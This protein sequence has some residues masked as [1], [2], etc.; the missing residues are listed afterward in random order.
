[1][2]ITKK[3]ARWCHKS[4]AKN[5]SARYRISV[6]CRPH[7]ALPSAFKLCRADL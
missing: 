6:R 1:L 3:K 7:P 2:T 5:G 4:L